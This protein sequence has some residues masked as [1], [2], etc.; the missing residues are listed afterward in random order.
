MWISRVS[1]AYF[2]CI[3]VCS[4]RC[5]LGLRQAQFGGQVGPLGQGEVLGLLEALV[6]RLELQTGVDGPRLPDLLPLSVEPHFPVLNDRRG[7][8]MLWMK[9]RGR[10]KEVS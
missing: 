3:Y 10:E 6:E 4:S 8:V 2:V 7:L 1:L 9:R 5:Y